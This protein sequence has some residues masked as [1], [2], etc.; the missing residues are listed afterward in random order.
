MLVEGGNRANNIARAEKMIKEAA[1]N[2]ADLVL[3]PEVMDLCWAHPSALQDATSIPDGET[4]RMLIKAARENKVYVCSGLAEKAGD[5]VYN[6][7]VLIS[8]EGNILIHHRKINEL[9]IAHQFYAVGESLHVCK[10]KFGT[11]G[12]MICADAFAAERVISQTLGYMGA[13]III[14]PTAWALPTDWDTTKLTPREIWYGHY[15]PVAKKFSLHIAG[16]SNV[17]M[18]TGGPWIGKMAIGNSLVIGPE[19]EIITEGQYGVD[20]EI[21]LY[22]DIKINERPVRGTNWE[23][24]FNKQ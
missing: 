18:L 12:L 22:S 14:S 2:G 21:I 24:Y 9:D 11:I 5:K 17:G 23:K 7:A 16:C 3:L 8:S 20:A 15:A 6:S 13:D 10:T 19:G 4:C 1:E